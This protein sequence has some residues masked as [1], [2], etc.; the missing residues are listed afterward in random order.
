MEAQLQ[1]KG[2]GADR[3]PLDQTFRIDE[4]V[5]RHRDILAKPTLRWQLRHRHENGL[6]SA[7]VRIGKHLLIIE[8]RYEEWLSTRAGTT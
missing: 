3:V 8:P 2:A 7:T 5:A 4:F 1:A 6:A